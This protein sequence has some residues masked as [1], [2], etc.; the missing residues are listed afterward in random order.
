MAGTEA[1]NDLSFPKAMRLGERELQLIKISFSG[2]NVNVQV[3]LWLMPFAK[4][5]S[6]QNFTGSKGGLWSHILLHIG[7]EERKKKKNQRREKKIIKSHVVGMTMDRK[8]R[9]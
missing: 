3:I 4:G 6:P 8:V 9:K 5:H 1:P 7:P 2:R